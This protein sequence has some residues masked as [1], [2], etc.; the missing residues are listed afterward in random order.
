[1]SVSCLVEPSE[2]QVGGL[3][4]WVMWD[5][6]ELSVWLGEGKSS[7]EAPGLARLET[8]WTEPQAQGRSVHLLCAAEL[9]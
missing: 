1:M 7:S 8:S 6:P 4:P 9:G 5:V 2:R 3:Q